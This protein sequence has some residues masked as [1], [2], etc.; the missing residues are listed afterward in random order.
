M[1]DISS[2]ASSHRPLILNPEPYHSLQ[3]PEA[4]RIAC[5]MYQ[6]RPAA[7][8]SEY[9]DVARSTRRTR[10]GHHPKSPRVKSQL[11]R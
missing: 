9:C 2:F 8:M 1:V 7:R 3:R 5:L 6:P 4:Q 10:C 11:K